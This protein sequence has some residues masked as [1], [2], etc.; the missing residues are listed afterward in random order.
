MFPCLTEYF[1]IDTQSTGFIPDTPLFGVPDFTPPP[2]ADRTSK[3]CELYDPIR[4]FDSDTDSISALNSS[5]G[6]NAPPFVD[7]SHLIGADGENSENGSKRARALNAPHG[8][9][10]EIVDTPVGITR[11]SQFEMPHSGTALRLEAGSPSNSDLALSVANVAR[12][13][14]PNRRAGAMHSTDPEPIGN[15]GKDAQRSGREILNLPGKP[16]PEISKKQPPYSCEEPPSVRS[17]MGKPNVYVAYFGEEIRGDDGILEDLVS[18]IES[19]LG[20]FSEMY[21]G[22]KTDTES[23]R[24]L[25][26]SRNTLMR[27][28]THI[29]AKVCG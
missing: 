26:A 8:R 6:S 22:E 27:E 17:D 4:S 28:N 7:R 18:H 1:E 19:S 13:S 14:A 5:C 10:S 9:P 2:S 20:P 24:A 15:G 21:A 16:F 25:V 12:P 3:Q 23:I 29:G 11:A